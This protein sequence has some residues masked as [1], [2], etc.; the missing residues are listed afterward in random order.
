MKG[1]LSVLMLFF[2]PYVIVQ[3]WVGSCVSL[4]QRN[5]LLFL[6]PMCKYFKKNTPVANSLINGTEYETGAVKRGTP[7]R[8][9]KEFPAKNINDATESKTEK[10]SVMLEKIKDDMHEMSNRINTYLD[11][12]VFI[13]SNKLADIIKDVELSKEEICMLYEDMYLGRLFE[14]LVAKLYYNKR[15]HGFVHLYNGQEAISSGIIKNLRNADYV[16]STYR[17]H[18]HA[19]SKNVP[20]SK[21]LNEL[22]GNYYGSTNKGKGGSMHIFSKE[23]NFIGGFAFIGEQ[24]PIGVG[25]AY[26]ILY[27]EN[28]HEHPAKNVCEKNEMTA[29]NEMKNKL[30][31]IHE[32]DNVKEKETDTDVVVCF[33]GDGTAN[34]GQ[35]YES[36]NLASSYNL[37]IMFV[38][39]NNNWAIGMENSRSTVNDM[40]SIYAKGKAFNMDTYKVDGNDVLSIYKLAKKKIREMRE[41]K[42]GPVLIE[43]ITYRSKGHSLADPDE[44][45]KPEEKSSWKK[46]D[47]INI[48]MD[49]MK[50][51]NIVDN[52]YFEKIK[53]ETQNLLKDVEKQA[54]ENKLKP[55][56]VREL[57]TTNIFAPSEQTPFQENYINYKK[58]EEFSDDELKKYHEAFMM[59]LKRKSEKQKVDPMKHFREKSLPLII[60]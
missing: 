2:V 41:K 6:N 28:F 13:E 58:Q 23:H 47:P 30:H 9:K 17:D 7:V 33:L 38:V 29:V 12:N 4:K 51:L 8:S 36:L 26:S 10:Y 18:V 50:K 53:T 43:A 24:I 27:K 3:F 56:N 35:F 55:M 42:I 57:L 37:P 11:N 44:L 19:L 22:Y 1:S 45:R 59:E 21:V 54:E 14:N 60:D 16:V 5:V 48:L 49:Y 32:N 40:L 46:V 31:T 25:L 34:I 39:E 52:S 15:V 20:A